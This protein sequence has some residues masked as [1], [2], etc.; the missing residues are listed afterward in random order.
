MTVAIPIQ[1]WLPNAVYAPASRGLSKESQWLEDALNALFDFKDS[2]STLGESRQSTLSALDALAE[3]SDRDDWDDFGSSA[4]EPST[5][6][7][8]RSFV[9]ML[10]IRSPAPEVSV[11]ADGEIAFE[12]DNG[13]RRV[14]SV[15]VGRDGTLSYAALLGWNKSYG[16]ARLAETLPWEIVHNLERVT[17]ESS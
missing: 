3:A 15:S 4:V 16:T 5:Y 1:S 13:P 9:R 12:W 2:V 14:L 8:A 11:D 17:S 6:E 7:Y 10:N